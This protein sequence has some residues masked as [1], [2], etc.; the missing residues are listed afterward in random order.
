MTTLYPLQHESIHALVYD[1]MVGVY[2]AGG[3]DKR[4]AEDWVGTLYSSLY[5]PGEKIGYMYC[6]LYNYALGEY[7]KGKVRFTDKVAAK[8]RAQRALSN[9]AEFTTMRFP[10]WDVGGAMARR[11]REMHDVED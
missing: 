4:V 1:E 7:P 5:S 8:V 3:V 10:P 6:D 9:L 11:H 2:V